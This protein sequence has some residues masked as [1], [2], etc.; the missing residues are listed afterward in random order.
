MLP[1]SFWGPLRD[2]S[3]CVP[4]EAWQIARRSAGSPGRLISDPKWIVP[5]GVVEIPGRISGCSIFVASV[6]KTES[7][8]RASPVVEFSPLIGTLL[9]GGTTTPKL[10]TFELSLPSFI[11]TAAPPF[12]SA[13]R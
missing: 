4:V 13:A 9:A 12:E 10:L 7:P 11:R 1:S 5:H 6:K 2:S 8:S 3:N